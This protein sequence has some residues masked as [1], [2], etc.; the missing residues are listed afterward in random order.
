MKPADQLTK[1]DIHLIQDLFLTYY[2]EAAHYTVSRDESQQ[3][4][5][6]IWYR[7]IRDFLL[8]KDLKDADNSS[9]N[10]K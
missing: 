3:F 1:A 5:V 10:T 8:H 9:K 7:A 2:R 4:L 6:R